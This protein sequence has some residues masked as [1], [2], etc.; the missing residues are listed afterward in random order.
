[1]VIFPDL[2]TVGRPELVIFH[3][4]SEKESEKPANPT[5]RYLYD[6]LLVAFA[7]LCLWYKPYMA[8]FK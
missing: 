6:F 8:T 5:S 3:A 4:T 1:M 7:L 2:V